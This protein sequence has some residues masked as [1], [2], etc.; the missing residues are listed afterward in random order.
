MLGVAA[1][2][3]GF[4]FFGGDHFP[5]QPRALDFRSGGFGLRRPA[6]AG[7]RHT[8]VA[9]GRHG[10]WLK[11]RSE[12][13]F[14]R[15]LLQLLGLPLKFLGAPGQ[16]L[17]LRRPVF[18]RPRGPGPGRP[19]GAQPFAEFEVGE[20]EQADQVQRGENDRGADLAEMTEEHRIQNVAQPSARARSVDV[21]RHS[22]E[23]RR[24]G[25]F[26]VL[27]EFIE[28]PSAGV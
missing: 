23:Q 10:Y 21:E 11:V 6:H 17:F 8:Q 26:R 27:G 5:F 4:V 1:T 22:L 16:G 25:K 15:L 7:G 14:L 18:F 9:H 28:Q 13:R 12:A 24:V 20:E 19:Q 3:I 2:A